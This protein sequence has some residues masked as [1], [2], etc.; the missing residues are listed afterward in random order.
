MPE[1]NVQQKVIAF[2]QQNPQYQGK[3]AESVLSAMLASG[4]ISHAEIDNLN[5]NNN[6]SAFGF[7]FE[8]STFELSLPKPQGEQGKISTTPTTQAQKELLKFIENRYQKTL[9]DFNQQMLEDGWAGDVIPKALM[10]RAQSFEEC[11]EWFLKLADEYNLPIIL[12]ILFKILIFIEHAFKDFL[13][14]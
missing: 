5:S 9:S 10:Y 7:G 6:V 14:I 2:V 8:D 11:P 13:S 4:E 3:P 1:L 12:K